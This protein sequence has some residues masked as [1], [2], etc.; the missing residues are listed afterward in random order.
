MDKRDLF[1]SNKCS[2]RWHVICINLENI[3]WVHTKSTIWK[4]SKD[5]VH[6]PNG[7]RYRDDQSFSECEK[8]WNGFITSRNCRWSYKNIFNSHITG[9]K[10]NMNV[11]YAWKYMFNF[12]CYPLELWPWHSK[13][14]FNG[15]V[16]KNQIYPNITMHISVFQGNKSQSNCFTHFDIH[17]YSW[18]L[19]VK[20][21][22]V[23]I[24]SRLPR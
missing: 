11:I 10:P 8:H 13:V 2:I 19:E 4:I 6:K 17:V 7:S 24:L 5:F 1:L 16:P 3:D 22:L 9:A 12:I 21:L 20:R 14:K 15:H 23:L 18:F